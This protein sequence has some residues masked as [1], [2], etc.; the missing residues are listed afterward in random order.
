MDCKVLI[1]N[2]NTLPNYKQT[3]K[4]CET[5]EPVTYEIIYMY[6]NDP[7]ELNDDLVETIMTILQGICSEIVIYNNNIIFNDFIIQLINISKINTI[8][9]IPIVLNS[10]RVIKVTLNLLEF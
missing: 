5:D 1:L 8:L 4:I 3:G 2:F 7:R 9:Y 6:I 10:N